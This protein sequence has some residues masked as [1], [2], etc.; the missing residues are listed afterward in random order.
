MLG[1]SGFD[2]TRVGAFL[3]FDLPITPRLP[4]EVTLS[5]GHQFVGSNGTSGTGGGEGT[6]V[7]VSF[8]SVF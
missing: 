5:A 7:G 6:Y 4:L 2:A 8:V 1:N 3:T